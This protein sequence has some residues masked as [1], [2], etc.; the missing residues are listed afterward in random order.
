MVI[1]TLHIKKTNAL[2]EKQVTTNNISLPKPVNSKTSSDKTSPAST[3]SA[4]SSAE[5]NISVIGHHGGGGGSKSPILF[6]QN[7]SIHSAPLHTCH[8][9]RDEIISRQ[10]APEPTAPALPPTE[11]SCE[12][13]QG[14]SVISEPPP[15]EEVPRKRVLSNKITKL[16]GNSSKVGGGRA[17]PASKN[18]KVKKSDYVIIVSS[19]ESFNTNESTYVAVEECVDSI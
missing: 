11:T 6:N 13:E 12:S 1:K 17:G 15:P 8:P 19:D 7:G 3:Q 16:V 14:I 10:A 18:K 5:A 9:N 4:V 2:L